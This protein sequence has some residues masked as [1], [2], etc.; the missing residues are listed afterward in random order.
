MLIAPLSMTLFLATLASQISVAT[1]EVEAVR[2]DGVTINVV[3]VKGILLLDPPAA[4]CSAAG[5]SVADL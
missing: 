5:M 2:D 4:A 1:A 3:C